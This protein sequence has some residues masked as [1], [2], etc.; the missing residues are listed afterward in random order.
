MVCRV[1]KFD[2]SY[3]WLGCRYHT[4][5]TRDQARATHWLSWQTRQSMLLQSGVVLSR[6]FRCQIAYISP[7]SIRISSR[8]LF[9][10]RS[11][12]VAHTSTMSTKAPPSDLPIH[13]FPSARDLEAFLDREHGTSLGFYLK[14]AKKS[15]GIASVSSAEA[16]ETA[17]CFGWIDGRANAYDENW[18]LVRYTPRRA[19]SIWSQKNVSTI[20]KL[21]SDGRI[22]PAGMAVVEAAKADGRWD[23]A[24]DGPASM[25]TPEDL[26]SALEGDQ[27]AKAFFESLNRTDRYSILHR[28]QTAAPRGREER[29]DA[30]VK[31]LARGELSSRSKKPV[32]KAK[33]SSAVKEGRI[34][35]TAA[36][37]GVNKDPE[38]STNGR[39][40][41][42]RNVRQKQL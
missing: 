24:Y 32:N 38:P 12:S 33:K 20:Q 11:S 10:L 37:K 16:V 21:I 27:D 18:W 34:V 42:P 39:R 17:L 25:K 9:L 28:L 31:T 29:I 22:R 13:S 7:H 3:S 1:I 2:S 40:L 26:S 23:R 4:T 8:V 14:L 5:K 36:T 41:R 15:S 35:K 19:K 6:L 30:L